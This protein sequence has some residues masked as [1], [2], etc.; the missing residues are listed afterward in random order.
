MYIGKNVKHELKSRM[1]FIILSLKLEIKSSAFGEF[2]N[3]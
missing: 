3:Y 1:Y 2:F